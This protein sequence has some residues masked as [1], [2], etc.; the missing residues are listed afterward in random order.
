MLMFLSLELMNMLPYMANG[1]RR[2]DWWKFWNGE[3]I[4]DY[5][6]G[7]CNHR[8]PY[9]LKREAR[10]AG[11][12]KEM[13]T[14]KVEVGVIWHTFVSFKDRKG[15]CAKECG[16]PLKAEK[17]KKSILPYNLQDGSPA[18]TLILAKKTHFILVITRSIRQQIYKPEDLS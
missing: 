6:L 3:I 14:T 5:L 18:N 2:H 7:T 17:V 1:L 9:K 4:M 12:E 8:G 16:W 13:W 11:S 10:E 15:P